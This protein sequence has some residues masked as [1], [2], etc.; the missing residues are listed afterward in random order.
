[1]TEV[2]SIPGELITAGV[3]GPVCLGWNLPSSNCVTL[4]QLTPLCFHCHSDEMGIVV[5]MLRVATRIRGDLK[6]AL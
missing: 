1:M 4:G 6:G 5:V 2:E 3:L